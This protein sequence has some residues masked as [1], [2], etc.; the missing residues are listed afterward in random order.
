MRD[1]NGPWRH[2]SGRHGS[3]YLYLWDLDGE[4]ILF[5]G[6]FP[7]RYELMPLRPVARDAITGEFILPRLIAAV[8]SGPEGGFVEYHF[9]DPNDD[10]DSVDIP[11][12]GYVRAFSATLPIGLTL[13]YV[14]GSGFYKSA[15]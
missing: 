2:D 3:I 6:G 12:V 14:V 10:T 4:I 9:D 1:P 15:P 13:N 5:H 7:N 8:E 11:K